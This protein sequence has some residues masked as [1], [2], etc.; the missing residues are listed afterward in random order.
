MRTYAFRG[1]P[2]LLAAVLA[3]STAPA[4]SAQASIS[5][6]A[7]L[8]LA[9]EAP[10]TWIDFLRTDDLAVRLDTAR[11]ERRD[12]G[13]LLVWVRFEYAADEPV[14][15]RPD[16]R[17]ARME[18]REALDCDAQRVADVELTIRDRA[19]RVL[20]TT[21]AEPPRWKTFVEHPFDTDLFILACRFLSPRALAG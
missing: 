1:L 9:A 14:P 12:D 21:R 4:A 16:E 17:Y 2:C 13:A 15:G 7:A 8:D 10:S 20:G 5:R 6:A 18:I 11:V 3:L 19:E